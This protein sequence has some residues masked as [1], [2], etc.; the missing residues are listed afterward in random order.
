MGTYL[1]NVIRD[2][3]YLKKD[4]L[5]ASDHNIKIFELLVLK[6]LKSER[7]MK[8]IK[9]NV[10]FNSISNKLISIERAIGSKWV[11]FFEDAKKLKIFD[12]FN[13]LI[14][15]LMR[16]LSKQPFIIPFNTPN[17][18][19]IQEENF[20]AKAVC[21]LYLKNEEELLWR[22][23]N[24]TDIQIDSHEFVAFQNIPLFGAH[25]YYAFS[26]NES[27]HN[28]TKFKKFTTNRDLKFLNEIQEIS[29]QIDLTHEES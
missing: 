27:V 23:T 2:N 28:W 12:K 16:K 11:T 8:I 4:G 3:K 17:T 1:D 22:K 20:D 15:L 25:L 24:D 7:G 6:R 5:L 29:E 9:L 21:D 10:N 18:P 14:R 26:P 13:P 19:N